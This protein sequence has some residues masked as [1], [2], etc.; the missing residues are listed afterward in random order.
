MSNYLIVDS[1]KKASKDLIL[2]LKIVEEKSI[3]HQAYTIEEALLLYIIHKPKLIFLELDLN[4]GNG[5]EL[6]HRL[7]ELG[8]QPKMVCVTK[9]KDLTIKAIRYSALDYLLK[10]VNTDDLQ[11]CLKRVKNLIKNELR[12]KEILE[13]DLKLKDNKT[14]Q[15]N[16][17][18]GFEVI[19]LNNILYCKADRNYTDI[20]LIGGASLTTSNTLSKVVQQLPSEFFFRIGRSAA[21]NLRYLKSVNRKEKECLLHCENDTYKLPMSSNRINQLS[22]VLK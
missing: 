14:I 18:V 20:R 10:P 21:I 22:E 12:Q 16:T 17:R 6:I 8:E 5:F 13:L 11:V 3:I 2:K 9:N 1:D 15:I 19:K 7:S 4:N